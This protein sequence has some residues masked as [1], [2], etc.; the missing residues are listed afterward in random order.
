MNSI[1]LIKKERAEQIRK[2]GRTVEYDKKHNGSG[3][4][5]YAAG[6][7]ATEL[8][9]YYNPAPMGWDENYWGKVQKKPYKER[10]IIAAAL[11]AAEIDRIS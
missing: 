2:H 6:V 5:L 11:L 9:Q 4:L 8:Y 7:L 10:L 1:Q 3:Q